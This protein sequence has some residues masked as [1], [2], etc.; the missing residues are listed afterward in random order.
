MP[1]RCPHCGSR[2]EETGVVSQYQTE[3]PEPR[4]EGIEF[5][6]HLGCCRRCRRAVQGRHPR[7]TSPAVGSAASQLG[8]RALALAAVLNKQ[9]KHALITFLALLRFP[10][11]YCEL[12]L[13][14]YNAVKL[15]K[16]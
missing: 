15:R 7:Q 5:R 4:V 14:G 3:I 11:E 13:G 10:L 2:V 6:I 9:L 12:G 1:G 8:P 16:A